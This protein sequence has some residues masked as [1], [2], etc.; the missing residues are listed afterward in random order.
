[1]ELDALCEAE[2][3]FRKT[4]TGEQDWRGGVEVVLREMAKSVGRIAA[5][6]AA[7]QTRAERWE[8]RM[9]AQENAA[10][11]R[12]S[13]VTDAAVEALAERLEAVESAV[14]GGA[15]HPADA[16]STA[17]LGDQVAALQGKLDSLESLVKEATPMQQPSADGSARG[18]PAGRA[19][20][21]ARSAA[22]TEASAPAVPV[23]VPSGSGVTGCDQSTP[24]LSMLQGS[25]PPSR[26]GSVGSLPSAGDRDA[27]AHAPRRLPDHP[28]APHYSKENAPPGPLYATAFR[29]PPPPGKAWRVPGGAGLSERTQSQANVGR[30]PAPAPAPYLHD[31]YH[32]DDLAPPSAPVSSKASLSSVGGRRHTPGMHRHAPSPSDREW[33]LVDAYPTHHHRFRQHDPPSDPLPAFDSAALRPYRSCLDVT[34]A[35]G[36]CMRR[37]DLREEA[38]ADAPRRR[39]SGRGPLDK[40]R[41]ET[42]RVRSGSAGKRRYSRDGGGRERAETPSRWGRMGSAGDMEDEEGAEAG[43]KKGKEK[44]VEKL[45]DKGTPRAPLRRSSPTARRPTPTR[46]SP[47]PDLSSSACPE[48]I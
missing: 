25:M 12:A 38:D 39:L 6:V 32:W 1:M 9:T 36:A 19:A 13:R 29:A 46:G 42:T 4:S 48:A 28:P 8:T 43:D 27:P 14:Q 47:W 21:Q 45:K 33:D 37:V 41:E 17:A 18:P 5:D 16:P 7:L 44:E 31:G 11:E 35:S 22:A 34:E 40:G 30:P 23:P 3:A 20:S 2:S 24:R 10:A 26:S 15:P